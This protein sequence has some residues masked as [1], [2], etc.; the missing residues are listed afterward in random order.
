LN[1]APLNP[2]DDNAAVAPLMISI[3]TELTQGHAA[4]AAAHLDAVLREH[5]ADL[6]TLESGWLVSVTTRAQQ[7]LAPN[8]AALSEQYNT[9]FDA[10]AK[11]MLQA[12]SA[13]SDPQVFYAVA[14]RYPLTQTARAALASAGDRAAAMGDVSSAAEYYRLAQAAGWTPD[15]VHQ[16][17]IETIQQALGNLPIGK[18]TA[19]N[20][21]L[22][23]ESN[24]YRTG[25]IRAKLFF[26]WC[27]DGIAYFVT[28]AHV[29]AWKESGGVL[30]SQ[31]IKLPQE[32]E[33]PQLQQRPMRWGQPMLV[34]QDPQNPIQF[35]PAVLS[36]AGSARVLVV[37]CG[38][39]P[40]GAA[41]SGAAP[42]ESAGLTALAA[43]DGHV[44]WST[45]ENE[46]LSHLWFNAAPVLEGRY[47]YA[48]A[49]D[50]AAQACSVLMLAL[51]VT[52]GR[53]IW[54]TTLGAVA[55]SV[56]FQFGR[57]GR[58]GGGQSVYS[59]TA[60]FSE[61]AG[62]AVSEDQLILSPNAGYVIALDRFDGSL[63]W[64]RQYPTSSDGGGNVYSSRPASPRYDNRPYV[65]NGMVIVAAQDA[66]S[67]AL[68]NARTGEKVWQSVQLSR[69]TLVGAVAGSAVFAGATL[70]AIDMKNGK[71]LWEIPSRSS[72]IDGP[73]IIVGGLIYAPTRAGL[74]VL[75]PQTGD[76]VRNAPPAP[77]LQGYLRQ[78]GL[79]ALL[80]NE[81]ALDGV[82]LP[83][84]SG[85]LPLP[86]N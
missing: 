20:G 82:F 19:F 4:D 41:Q 24:G 75:D 70:Q 45:L 78:P 29:L 9:Q 12:I 44:L 11:Q 86:G 59:G 5:S 71:A 74:Q 63:R 3:Q 38:A 34:T 81:G 21:P 60:Q 39:A 76:P 64:M 26:P 53:E 17:R 50:Q 49:T 85:I 22:P 51:D 32:L 65:A 2:P 48:L 72:A 14:Q 67:S 62:I 61:S 28:N 36:S 37:R 80:A 58:M 13:S 6:I 18:T 56:Q 10:S 79:R 30:W 57:R 27:A 77:T 15:A 47:V 16:H 33:P 1:A 68:Y 25:A 69:S 84:E 52:S 23:F 55:P 35:A 8:W 83:V 54:R 43:S 40:S 31:P 42:A 73:P 46:S 66:P 7:L